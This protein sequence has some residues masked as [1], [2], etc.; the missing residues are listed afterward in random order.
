MRFRL[1]R[2]LI[3]LNKVIFG[4]RIVILVTKTNNIF[5][6]FDATTFIIINK[7]LEA[8]KKHLKG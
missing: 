3:R 5:S 7:I 1:Y 8:V 2:T 4:K 6:N